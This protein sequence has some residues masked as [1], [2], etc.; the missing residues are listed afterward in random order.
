MKCTSAKTVYS[1]SLFAAYRSAFN[2]LVPFNGIA[3]VENKLFE[4]MLV[5]L[6][7]LLKKRRGSKWLNNG[8][9]ISSISNKFNQVPT[10]LTMQEPPTN[11]T[12]A[13]TSLTI[14]LIHTKLFN[15]VSILSNFFVKAGCAYVIKQT[16]SVLSL[17]KQS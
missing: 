13:C 11:R 14:A 10:P 4:H 6:S 9:I 12:G 2:V 16:I 17:E 7:A 3:G 5:M 15:F 1:A 8:M